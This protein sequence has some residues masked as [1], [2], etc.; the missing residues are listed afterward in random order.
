MLKFKCSTFILLILLVMLTFNHSADAAFSGYLEQL[1]LNFGLN[2]TFIPAAEGEAFRPI[3]GGKIHFPL[4]KRW[5]AAVDY[6]LQEDYQRMLQIFIQHQLAETIFEDTYTS[7]IGGIAL[8]HDLVDESRSVGPLAGMLFTRH[9]RKD[10]Y[11]HTSL[12]VSFLPQHK[13]MLGFETGFQYFINQHLSFELTYQG[14]D[15]DMHGLHF[16][17]NIHF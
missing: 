16:G 17:A 2:F 11:S 8:Y 4:D 9:F 12:S 3:V 10:W 5:A 7:F 1:R 13:I 6:Y 14:R 15:L